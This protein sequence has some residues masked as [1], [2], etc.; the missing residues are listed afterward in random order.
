MAVIISIA[1]E[2][3]GVAKTTTAVS[4]GA[5]MVESGARV[6]LIDLDAQ[7]NLTLAL[8]IEPGKV[9]RSAGN[10][11]LESAQ[12]SLVSRETGIPGLEIIPANNEMVYTERYLP[13]RPGYETVLRKA[14]Q[15]PALDYDFIILDC[16]PFLGAVTMNALSASNL[17]LMPTQAE[18]FSIYALRNM[19]YLIRRVRA[20]TNPQLTYRLLI[21]MFDRRNRIHRTLSEQLHTTFSDGLLQTVIETDTRLRESPIAGLPVIYHSPKTRSAV[22]YR[23]LAQE[24]ME[25]VKETTAE[26]A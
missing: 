6:L 26:P 23:A 5:A 3:G 22:Q 10:I 8:G 21:T 24:I 20:Q 12:P 13:S 18:Y 25:Y 4:L 16:P 14:L 9:Q 15:D 19:M 7:A 1:N 17:L 2:K 11:L